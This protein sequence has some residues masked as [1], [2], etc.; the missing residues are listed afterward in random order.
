MFLLCYSF[1]YCQP[2]ENYRMIFCEGL[3]LPNL[4][5]V[6]LYWGGRRTVL[7][8]HNSCASIGVHWVRFVPLIHDSDIAMYVLSELS[9]KQFSWFRFGSLSLLEN[10]FLQ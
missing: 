3:N 5:F 6:V 4:L 2:V 7:I 10:Y 8:T 9:I 1:D